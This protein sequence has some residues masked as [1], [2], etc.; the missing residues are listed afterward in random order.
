MMRFFGSRA[1]A[2]GAG[3]AGHVASL[4]VPARIAAAKLVASLVGRPGASLGLTLSPAAEPATASVGGATTGGVA[5]AADGVLAVAAGIPRAAA[6]STFDGAPV[7][8]GVGVEAT[9]PP[10]TPERG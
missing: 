7:S 2:I 5:A 6:E 3:P 4:R 1:P 10:L 9:S 8:T